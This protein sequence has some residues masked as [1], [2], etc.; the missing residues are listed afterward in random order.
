[1]ATKRTHVMTPARRAALKKAQLASAKA[2]RI[3]RASR[4]RGRAPKRSN[5]GEGVSGLKKNVV[6]YVRVN[7]RSQTVGYNTGTI[8][9][10]SNSRLVV[11]TY[12]RRES[13]NKKNGVDKRIEEFMG[14]IAPKNSKRGKARAYVKKNV[15]ITNPALRAN[16]RGSQVRL[17]TSRGAGPTIVVRRG[18][19]KVSE[20]A[21]RKAIKRYDTHARKLN[22]KRQGKPR[23]Q[24]RKSGRNG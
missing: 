4:N 9:T 24:R 16:L 18:R 12:V 17:S 5:R 6:P 22:A 14:A 13:I 3:K 20:Q 8:V 1:M 23:P 15:V 19:H 7:K 10:G 2:R 11:G 21:S